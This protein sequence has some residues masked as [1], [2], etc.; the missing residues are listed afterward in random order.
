VAGGRSTGMFFSR[1]VHTALGSVAVAGLCTSAGALAQAPQ[2]PSPS[3]SP[4]LI[5][6]RV[7]PRAPAPPPKPE[8]PEIKPQPA[9]EAVPDALKAIKIT[10]K[11][12]RIEAATP[13]PP[14]Q[15]RQVADVT[16]GYIGRE[17]TGHDVF[18]L[19]RTLTVT[20]RNLGYILSQVVVPPQS[21]A[22]GTLRLRV[23]EGYIANVRIEGDETVRSTLAALGEKIKASRPLEARTLERY[24]L[25]A[26][27]LPG[28]RV[29][30]VL[31]PSPTAGAAD[32]TLIAEVRKAEGYASLDNYGSKYLGP[33]QL[34]LSLAG[35][36]LLGVNDQL[37]FVGVTTGSN[38]EMNFGQLS[39][40]QTVGTEGLKLA[41]I[42]S[43]TSTRPGDVL[44]QFDIRGEA[45]SAT[46][47]AVYPLLRTRNDSVFGRVASDH[48]DVNSDILGTRV[49]QD[50]IRAL[51]L[52]ATWL[53][54]DRID[55]YNTL[56]VE[57]SA[58]LGGTQQDDP[59]RSRAD[60][61]GNYRK[62]MFDYERVQPIGAGY[63]LTVGLGGQWTDDALLTSEQYA[64]GGRRFGRAYD[65]AELVG[66]KAL[67]FRM[68]PAYQGFGGGTLRSYQPYAF[69]DVGKV[70]NIVNGTTSPQ[71]SASLASAG[72]GVR[73]AFDRNITATLEAAWPLT[74]A[75]ASY[76]TDGQGYDVRIHG[77]LVVR[78]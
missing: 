40:S 9:P 49:I 13:L 22:E 20:Y 74:K 3:V 1:F 36:Q 47:L 75:V 32:L 4:G 60:A 10:L 26:N 62:V 34:A 42:V 66:D 45:T 59:L 16:N 41:A 24:L 38:R 58:G 70:W 52:G 57:Y 5:Q 15:A 31:S 14:A 11:D 33:G 63:S 37:R 44:Q 69:Y 54:L 7:A 55:G 64:L 65:P 39:Y 19:A 68:E 76:Q 77:S 67:A 2:Q 23:I 8:L 21:L 61:D 48:R 6:E 29:R 46:A 12:I 30:A 56:D 35:N 72:F 71:Y 27:D 53:A 43:Q 17:I 18:D 50:R 25:I 73:L 51:R 78:F 28:V